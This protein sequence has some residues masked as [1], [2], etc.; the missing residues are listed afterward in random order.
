MLVSIG[1]RR[2]REAEQERRIE[3]MVQTRKSPM[4]RT[5]VGHSLPFIYSSIFIR[6]VSNMELDSG[7]E[8]TIRNGQ[9]PSNG[10]W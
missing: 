9:F 3:H 7:M 5:W 2:W 4:G 6:N 10:A 8:N 1:L